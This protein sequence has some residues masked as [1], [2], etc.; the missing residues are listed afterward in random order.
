MV[1]SRGGGE[2]RDE[3][4]VIHLRMV[5]R[6]SVSIQVFG[7]IWGGG[8]RFSQ[9][10]HAWVVIN[11]HVRAISATFSRTVSCYCFALIHT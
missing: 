4:S 8:G 1:S 5:P 7:C 2:L 11:R 10:F 9:G 6:A 3:L